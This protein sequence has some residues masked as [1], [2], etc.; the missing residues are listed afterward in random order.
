[1][2]YGRL[3]TGKDD[4]N[5]PSRRAFES[6]LLR[7][8]RRRREG[9]DD[10]RTALDHVTTS[11]PHIAEWPIGIRSWSGADTCL[12]VVLRGQRTFDA[13]PVVDVG[14]R[15]QLERLHLGSSRSTSRCARENGV[16]DGRRLDQVSA[17]PMA[18]SFRLD[19]C[20]MAPSCPMN[21]A[22]GTRALATAPNHRRGLAEPPECR[23]TN[24]GPEFRGLCD[25]CAVPS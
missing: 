15:R 23:R 3:E 8:E 4:R 20:G 22:V 13:T 21:T 25:V 17:S 14:S 11:S 19:V 18:R 6:D 2:K 1:M 9:R 5:S 10:V 12:L 7:D 16:H 24:G